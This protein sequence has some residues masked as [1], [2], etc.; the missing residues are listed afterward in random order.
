[1]YR[2]FTIIGIGTL[3]GYIAEALANLENTEEL[4]FVDFDEVQSK[5]LINSIYRPIDVGLRKVEALKDIISEKNSDLNV[6]TIDT[7]FIERYTSLPKSDLIFDCRDFIYDR[8]GTINI[9][10]YISARSVIVDC[11]KYVNYKVHHEGRY[12]S[13]LTK[14]DLKTAAFIVA[15]LVKSGEIKTLIDTNSVSRY[16]IDFIKAH[17]ESCDI[18]YDHSDGEDRLINFRENIIPIIEANKI[19][20]LEIL[21]GDPQNPSITKLIPRGNIK[22]GGDIILN[23]NFLINNQCDYQN[24]IISVKDN[25][26][27]LVPETGAA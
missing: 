24:Y 20:D 1:M 13:P 6:K 11:R 25:V 21:I 7:C 3:G 27:E 22:S 26:V 14:D 9:R 8:K 15:S 18:I 17:S 10:A 4:T 23:L 2:T 5:N 19:K 12:I 16:D